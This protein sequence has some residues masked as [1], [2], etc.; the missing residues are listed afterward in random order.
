[1]ML[2]LRQ[3]R[4]PLLW[5]YM[6]FNKITTLCQK[7]AETPLPALTIGNESPTQYQ[8]Q[9]NVSMGKSF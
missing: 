3:G 7:F 9:L 5:K 4:V 1:M 8:S 6:G 2:A